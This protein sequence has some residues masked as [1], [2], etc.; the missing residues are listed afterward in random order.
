[1]SFIL[2]ALR[3]AAKERDRQIPVLQRLLAPP[4]PES[5]S[6]STRASGRLFA[7]LVLNAGLLLVLLALWLRPVLVPPPPGS[8]TAS[9]PAAS[10]P[11]PPAAPE[12]RSRT[13]G[14]AGE[15]TRSGRVPVVE[16]APAAAVPKRTPLE[17][18]RPKRALPATP[19]EPATVVPRQPSGSQRDRPSPARRAAPETVPAATP[20]AA[21]PGP[22]V[23]GRVPGLRIEALIYSDL[24]SM[25]MIFVNGKKYVEGDFIDGRIR[26]EEI[27]DNG[28]AL[29]DQGHRFTLPLAR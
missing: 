22:A 18:A 27:R 2:D 17:P 16:S 9:D 25:R 20:A 28:V 3:K 19:S 24:P 8:V 10:L 6:I 15:P 5:T 29:D 12:P 1:M 7:A 14:R 11:S 21:P 13:E 4:D 23:V 26:V